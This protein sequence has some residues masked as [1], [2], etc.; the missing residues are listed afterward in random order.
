MG[1]ERSFVTAFFNALPFEISDKRAFWNLVSDVTL[2]YIRANVNLL[3]YHHQAEVWLGGHLHHPEGEGEEE[4]DHHPQEAA[5]AAAEE[6]DLA[7]CYGIIVDCQVSG[8]LRKR[9][10]Q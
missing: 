8:P 4:E 10:S 2:Q 3:C 7:S 9:K 1:A 5:A 6:G